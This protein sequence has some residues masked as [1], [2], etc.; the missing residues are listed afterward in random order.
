[1]LRFVILGI[2]AAEPRY[3]YELKSVFEELL[4]GTWPL[5]IGQVYTTLAKLEE[6]GYVDFEV[7]PQDGT[8]DRK[9][10][11]V[12][13]AGHDAL[14]QWTDDVRAGPVRLRDELYLKVL[15]RSLASSD[16]ARRLVRRQR[17]VLLRTL[18]GLNKLAPEDVPNPQAALLLEGAM[19]RLEADLEWLDRCERRLKEVR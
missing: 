6:D 1:M 5:N 9:V 14:D 15:V 12:T 19:L 16:S 18:A 11:R 4:G 13:A 2:L 7:V 8:P 10:Y 3:G 17:S